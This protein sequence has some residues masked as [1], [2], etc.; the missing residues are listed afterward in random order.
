M[1]QAAMK[2][3]RLYRA[4]RVESKRLKAKTEEFVRL[5]DYRAPSGLPQ[6]LGLAHHITPLT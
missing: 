1:N 4:L 2:M 6:V 5:L 3:Q